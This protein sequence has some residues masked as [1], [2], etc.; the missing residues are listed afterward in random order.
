M[1]VY[2]VQAGEG[3]PIK[4]GFA[5]DV[6]SRLGKMRVDCP[7]PLTLLAVAEG[8]ASYE[9]RLHQQFEGHLQRGEWFA[10]APELLALVATLPKPEPP[11]RK[12]KS[13][14]H[15]LRLYR[16]DRGLTLQELARMVGVTHATISRIEEQRLR[17]NL[18]LVI[19]LS[20]ATDGEVSIEQI[21]RWG[22]TANRLT[23][24]APQ[25]AQGGVS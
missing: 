6:P 24:A 1:P 8:D 13:G 5:R 21:V 15:P 3:G 17:P 9:S 14:A 16:C 25:P 23:P 2:F 19:R 7:I 4:I 12:M 10:P 18:G 11:R 22:A 20:N